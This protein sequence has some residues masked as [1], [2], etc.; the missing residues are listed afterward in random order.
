[1]I[2]VHANQSFYLNSRQGSKNGSP[3]AIENSKK[4]ANVRRLSQN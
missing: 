4:D 3:T 2:N 1:M